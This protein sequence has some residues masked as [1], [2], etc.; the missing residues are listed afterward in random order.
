MLFILCSTG[1]RT[2]GVPSVRTDLGAP[3]IKRISDRTNY[4]EEGTMYE[5]LSPTVY[6]LFGVQERHLFCPR[7]KDKVGKHGS[8]VNLNLDVCVCINVF[9]SSRIGIYKLVFGRKLLA[10]YKSLSTLA[11]YI[12]NNIT[13]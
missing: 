10:Q 7:T 1:F 9:H 13:I 6:S 12:T 3:L 4:G 2:Y 11:I 8:C 5:L